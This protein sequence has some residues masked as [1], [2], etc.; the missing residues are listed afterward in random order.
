M[1]ANSV[2]RQLVP[3]ELPDGLLGYVLFRDLTD[4]DQAR[5]LAQVVACEFWGTPQS[6]A[7]AARRFGRPLRARATATL[8]LPCGRAC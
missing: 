1:D 2:R 5:L 7:E 4:A 6:G 3:V 8:R